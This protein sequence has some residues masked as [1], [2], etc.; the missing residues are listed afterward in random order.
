MATGGKKPVLN[1]DDMESVSLLP[2]PPAGQCGLAAPPAKQAP[3]A[4][5]GEP[6]ALQPPAAPSAGQT[7]IPPGTVS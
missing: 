5:P 6:H 2:A 3:T 7:T 4:P 1:K